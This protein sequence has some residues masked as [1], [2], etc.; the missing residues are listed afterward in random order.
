MKLP[1]YIKDSAKVI[2]Y[3]AYIQSIYAFCDDDACII[4][5]SD[6]LMNRYLQ[7]APNGKEY[8]IKKTRFGEIIEGLRKGAAYAFDEDA[9]GRFISCANNNAI[10]DLPSKDIF[11]EPPPP[12]W[13]SGMHFLRI[14]IVE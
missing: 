2:G 1:N 5:G 12:D 9:Y 10:E 7:K 11:L 13:N 8:T 6:V 14:Q 4:A 3:F